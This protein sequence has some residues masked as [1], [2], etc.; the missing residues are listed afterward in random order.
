MVENVQLM[1]KGTSISV[2]VRDSEEVMNSFTTFM[3]LYKLLK[4][5]FHL[6]I[7]YYYIYLIVL[8]WR[9][10]KMFVKTPIIGF[11]HIA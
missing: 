3:N 7:E 10:N 6:E 9:L 2:R 5:S 11:W 1:Y 8:L 4:H